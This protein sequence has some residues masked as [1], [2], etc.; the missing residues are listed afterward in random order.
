MATERK[1]VSTAEFE[2]EIV[3]LDGDAAHKKILLYGP[4]G[5]GKTVIAGSAPRSLILAAEPGYISAARISLNTIGRQKRKLR[6]IRDSATALAAVEWLEDGNVEEFDWVIVDGATTLEHKVRLGYAAEAWDANPA[7]R[8]HR[9][10]PDKPD[11]FNTQNF[12]L[13]WVARL[14]DLPVN[15][16]ITCHDMKVDDEVMPYFQKKEGALSNSICGLMHVVGF[17]RK[18]EIPK[19]EEAPARDIYRIYFQRK[20]DSKND[21]TYFAKDQFNALGRWMD[22]TSIPEISAKIDS[23]PSNSE[24]V[25]E[26]P[27]PTQPPARKRADTPAKKAPAKKTAGRT[28]RS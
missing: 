6:K 2:R 15:L 14:V 28:K 21:I 11:Y 18:I 8:Q 24:D 19:S 9:N 25:G 13:G 3:D 23:S 10:L 17:V 5:V 4:S 16:I 7:K 27:E 12:M 22:N 1:P 20:H 26:T